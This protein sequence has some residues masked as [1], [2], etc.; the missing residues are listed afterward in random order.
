MH[1]ARALSQSNRGYI[2]SLMMMVY[3]LTDDMEHIN[4]LFIFLNARNFLGGILSDLSIHR[5]SHP[6]CVLQELRYL[7]CFYAFDVLEPLQSTGFIP[8]PARNV[9]LHSWKKVSCC[10][11]YPIPVVS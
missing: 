11:V 1:K 2:N 7:F 5:P 9:L 10:E 6:V 4:I 3:T 8:F